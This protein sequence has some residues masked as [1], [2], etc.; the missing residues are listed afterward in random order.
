MIFC[1]FSPFVPTRETKAPTGALNVLP[2]HGRL[3][4]R[5]H[6]FTVRPTMNWNSIPSEMKLAKSADSF[7][8]TYAKHRDQIINH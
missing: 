1:L 8:V 3:D 2:K 5:K 7:K 4:I 6:F